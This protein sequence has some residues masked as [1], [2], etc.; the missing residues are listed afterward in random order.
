M[1]AIHHATIDD[2]KSAG[3]GLQPPADH[4]QDSWSRSHAARRTASPPIATAR[5]PN[6]P[7]P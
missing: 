7:P 6:V 1:G 3:I 4:R 2:V 5:E